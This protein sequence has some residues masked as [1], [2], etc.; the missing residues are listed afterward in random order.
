MNEADVKL[1]NKTINFNHFYI[2]TTTK[3]HPYYLLRN[4]INGLIKYNYLYLNGKNPKDVTVYFRKVPYSV[5]PTLF[6]DFINNEFT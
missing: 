5:M 6:K 1:L 4:I 3:M 2:G